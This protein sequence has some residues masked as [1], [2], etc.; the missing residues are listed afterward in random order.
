MKIVSSHINI[1]SF[2]VTETKAVLPQI[3]LRISRCKGHLQHFKA[4]K[5]LDFVVSPTPEQGPIWWIF[6]SAVKKSL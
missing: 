3:C 4:S 5:M 2:T 6:S 1:Q